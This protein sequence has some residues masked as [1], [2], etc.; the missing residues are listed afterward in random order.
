[1][2]AV[3]GADEAW[4][5]EKQGRSRVGRAGTGFPTL[6]TRVRV[7]VKRGDDD[8]TQ[9]DRRRTQIQRRLRI[10]GGAAYHYSASRVV[11]VDPT[12]LFVPL[13]RVAGQ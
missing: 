13:N 6:R 5:T 11:H 9:H 12:T 8:G 3:I 1:M 4:Y 2:D 7:R 10:R